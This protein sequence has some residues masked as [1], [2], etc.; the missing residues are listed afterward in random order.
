MLHTTSMK[1][2]EA[3]YGKTYYDAYKRAR[4][5]TYDDLKQQKL[6][7]DRGAYMTF[8]EEKVTHKKFGKS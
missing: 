6:L 8:L 4:G 7:T 3:K 1:K 5:V 2:N